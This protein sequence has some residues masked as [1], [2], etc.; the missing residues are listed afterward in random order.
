[1]CLNKVFFQCRGL[2]FRVIL[3]AIIYIVYKRTK[4]GLSTIPRKE[5]F[6]RIMVSHTRDR[7]ALGRTRR[8]RHL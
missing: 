5:E 1:M 6:V 4:Q 3:S 8:V 7:V 2:A